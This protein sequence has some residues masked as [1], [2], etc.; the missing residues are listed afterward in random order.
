MAKLTMQNGK[1]PENKINFENFTGNIDISGGNILLEPTIVINK[2]L[3]A[4]SAIEM[5]KIE[6][7]IMPQ[8]QENNE[9]KIKTTGKIGT[10]LNI[11]TFSGE[12]KL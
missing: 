2:D 5:A 3:L 12:L 10:Q 11:E 6:A 9:M 8:A 7:E 1:E 4:E